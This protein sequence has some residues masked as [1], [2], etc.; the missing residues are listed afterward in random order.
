MTERLITCRRCGKKVPTDRM[1]YFKDAKNL[2][3]VDCIEKIKNPKKDIV[4]PSEDKTEK[5]KR[6]KCN[7]CKHIFTLKPNFNKQCPYC[8]GTKVTLQEWNSDLDA[9]IEESGKSIYNN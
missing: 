1:R 4:K 8:G 3:C 2:I 5:K 6:Y 7:K 9:L